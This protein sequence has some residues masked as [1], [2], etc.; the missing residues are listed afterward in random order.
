[1]TVHCLKDG[2]ARTWPRDPATEIACPGCGA[3]IGKKC[4]RPSGHTAWGSW[5]HDARDIAAC[6]AGHYG[7]CP[8][9]RCGLKDDPDGGA[10]VPPALPEQLSLFQ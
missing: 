5:V 1:M 8:S 10:A 7:P 2:C 6:R 9:G 4:K 3:G